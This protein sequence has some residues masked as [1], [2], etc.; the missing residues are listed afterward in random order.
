M[1]LWALWRA[2]ELGGD[3]C[4]SSVL[5]TELLPLMPRDH[6]PSWL[7]SSFPPPKRPLDSLPL[8]PAQPRTSVL[9]TPA[10]QF[11]QLQAGGWRFRFLKSKL[12]DFDIGYK[13][14]KA[15]VI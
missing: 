5:F 3:A 1:A 14:F 4:G 12:T 15:L 10:S 6:A 11:F 8:H 2:T 9:M 13:T 7:P